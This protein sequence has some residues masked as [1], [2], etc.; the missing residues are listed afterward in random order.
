[1][2]VPRHMSAPAPQM[3]AQAPQHMQPVHQQQ[4][5]PASYTS[6]PQSLPGLFSVCLLFLFCVTASL[7]V[8]RSH[9]VNFTPYLLYLSHVELFL[10]PAS[11]EP[12]APGVDDDCLPPGEGPDIGMKMNSGN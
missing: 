3:P 2:Q 11:E 12:G 7:V 8:F 10:G 6:Q 4:Q 5:A 1:M 9:P